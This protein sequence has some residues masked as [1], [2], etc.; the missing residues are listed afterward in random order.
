M[1]VQ[2][3]DYVFAKRDNIKV[4]QEPKKESE[5]WQRTVSGQKNK[6][7]DWIKGAQIGK[8]TGRMVENADGTFVEVTC[9]LIR[10]RKRLIDWVREDEI[11]YLLVSD[12]SFYYFK[13][14]PTQPTAPANTPVPDT[15]T[16]N[17][18]GTTGN[19]TN[20]G[21]GSGTDTTGTVLWVVVAVLAIVAGFLGFKKLSK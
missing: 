13:N 8:A 5:L 17:G 7:F 4:Y 19:G 14:L 20:N 1:S 3:N 11:G 16:G 21:N 9:E 12:D 10:W 15:L 18:S 2:K 6:Y